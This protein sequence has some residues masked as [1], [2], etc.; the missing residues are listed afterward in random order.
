MQAQRLF[1]VAAR[2]PEE[3]RLRQDER[4]ARRSPDAA[5]PAQPAAQLP[6]GVVQTA[7]APG[8]QPEAEPPRTPRLVGRSEHP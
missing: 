4:H 8:H 1:R 5:E 6:L 2:L 7:P 3:A